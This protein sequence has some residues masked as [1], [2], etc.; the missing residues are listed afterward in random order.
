MTAPLPPDLSPIPPLAQA[1]AVP[2]TDRPV[3]PQLRLAELTDADRSV[4]EPLA[5]GYKAFYNTEV[6]AAG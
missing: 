3:Q 4:W 2:P 5:R 1:S 6:D